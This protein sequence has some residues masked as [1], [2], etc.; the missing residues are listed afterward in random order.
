MEF[1]AWISLASICLMGAMTPGPSLFVVLKHTVAGGRINGV[2]TSIAHGIGVAMY[3]TLTV[4]GLAIIIESTPWLF[5]LI[6]YAGVILLIWLAYKALTSKSS[7]AKIIT[8]KTKVTMRESFWEGLIIAFFNPKLAV[9]FLALFS[10][11]VETQASWQQNLIMVV[12]V[13]GIDTL[14]YCL[15][16]IV[17]SQS[18]ILTKLKNN[19]HIVEKA[20]GVALLVV[21]AR[22]AF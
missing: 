5:N 11:F 20:T 21:A 18:A 6:K 3:A 4:I 17:L 14:W 9:F 10:Q 16:A 13:G 12:T 15:I 1:T 2:L 22:I 7:L 8:Q 19:V